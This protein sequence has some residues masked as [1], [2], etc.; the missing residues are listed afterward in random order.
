MKLRRLL[1]SVLLLGLV[2]LGAARAAGLGHPAHP[3]GGGRPAQIGPGATSRGDTAPAAVAARFAAAL[4]SYDWRSGE[5][6][7]MAAAARSAAPEVVSSL[8]ASPGAPALDDER[9]RRHEVV[10]VDRVDATVD[11]ATAADIGYSLAVTLT[12]TSDGGAP[13]SGLRFIE[14]RVSERGPQW[15]V[16]G[17]RQ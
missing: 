14:V 3:G 2:L 10:S 9:R 12:S 11:D 8:S 15:L 13:R 17:V 6:A 7:S 16:S 4:L 5:V 1:G